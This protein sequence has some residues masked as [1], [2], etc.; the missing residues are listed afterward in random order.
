MSIVLGD[1]T[2]P[3]PVLLAPMSGVTDQPFRRLVRG[4][5]AGLVVSEM[6]ASQAMIRQTRDSMKMSSGCADEYPMAVQLAGADPAVMAEAACLN[7]DRG[8]ALIDINFGCP[9]KKVVSKACGSALMREPELAA[10]I[11]DAVVRA[12]SPIPVTVKMRLGWDD[13]HRNAPELARLCELSGAQM[14]TIHGRT[15]VQLY[16]GEADWNAVQAVRD[17]VGIPVIVNGD[18]RTLQDVD[19]A[20]TASGADGVMV[21]RG[22]Y[23]RPWFIRDVMRHVTGE[24]AREAPHGREL[25]A[26]VSDHYEAI[27][28]HYGLHT[29]VRIARKHLAWY[30][31][32]GGVGPAF[33]VAVNAETDPDA[34][35]Q[36]IDRSFADPTEAA[37]ALAA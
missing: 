21:G 31:K 35:F 28:S 25:G 3:V 7:L 14:V 8:A 15:R 11:V 19:A 24:E 32:T 20:M 9:V 26:V 29:G 12:V 34:V 4:F 1:I 37:T 2:L 33:R 27:L 16:N 36:L 5:G 22:T 6:I 17:A 18:I 13:D 30:A 23:G 10:K